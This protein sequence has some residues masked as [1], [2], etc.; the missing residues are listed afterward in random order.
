MNIQN[1][2]LRLECRHRD[3]CADDQWHRQ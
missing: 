3:A 2:L 1:A